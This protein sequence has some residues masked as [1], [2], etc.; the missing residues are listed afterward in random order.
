MFSKLW[1]FV[2]GIVGK[3][4]EKKPTPEE[5]RLAV[6][7]ERLKYINEHPQTESPKTIVQ[8]KKLVHPLTNE[9][10]Q[11]LKKVTEDPKSYIKILN[12][13]TFG[14]DQW[15]YL[16]ELVKRESTWNPEAV[17]PS[18]GAYGL[19]QANPSGGQIPPSPDLKSQWQWGYNYIKSRYGTPQ[20][21]MEF[22]NQNGYY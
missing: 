10:V 19:F 17:N 1:N 18:S 8:Q 22:H 4:E 3:K 20:K 16:E 12:D 14:E 15:P 5:E 9:E 11:P 2:K 7:A 6:D 21:A 13:S